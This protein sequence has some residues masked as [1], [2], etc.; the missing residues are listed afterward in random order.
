MSSK[1]PPIRAVGMVLSPRSAIF[2]AS[3]HAAS[4]FSDLWWLTNIMFSIHYGRQTNYLPATL[5]LLPGG[6]YSMSSSSA[7]R[8]EMP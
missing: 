4:V 2:L 8:L 7:T 6:T 3:M 5:L 1:H